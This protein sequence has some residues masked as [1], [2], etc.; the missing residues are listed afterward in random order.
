MTNIL[1][2]TLFHDSYGNIF[3]LSVTLCFPYRTLD[4]VVD[5]HPRAVRVLDP[6][7]PAQ[8]VQQQVRDC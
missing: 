6:C 5:F 8:K 3:R 1:I 4:R 2:S 7:E